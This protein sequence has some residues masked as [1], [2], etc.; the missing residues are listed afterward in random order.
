MDHARLAIDAFI[1][2]VVAIFV[3]AVLVSVGFVVFDHRHDERAWWNE[4]D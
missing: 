3:A 2:L 1:V 4:E